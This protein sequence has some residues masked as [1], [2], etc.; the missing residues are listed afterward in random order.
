MTYTLA[1]AVHVDIR[2]D[3][4]T[5]EGD[6]GPGDVEL[7]APIAELLVNQG[8]AVPTPEKASKKSATP[9]DPT[10]SEA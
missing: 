10:P 7:P 3:N 8:L 9:T 6:F 5:I 4:E 1:E 2:I